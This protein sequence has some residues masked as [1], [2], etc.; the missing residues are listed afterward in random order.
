MVMILPALFSGYLKNWFSSA[1]F[2]AVRQH[3]LYHARR[4]LLQKVDRVVDEHVVDDPH[5]LFVAQRLHDARALVVVHVGE[6]VRRHVLRQQPEHH[7][8]P[9]VVQRFE[10]FGDVH[11]V[12]H[13]QRAEKFG[14][15]VGLQQRVQLGAN[16]F[17]IHGLHPPLQN[18]LST[19]KQTLLAEAF[20]PRTVPFV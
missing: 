19:Q 8:H 2:V 1:L 3:A 7:Q 4:Q 9:L 14:L 5:G 18:L 6:H 15:F 17:K 10:V 16:S 13:I 11:L 12:E 20:L